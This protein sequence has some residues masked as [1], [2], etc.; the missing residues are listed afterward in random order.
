MALSCR[1]S[2]MGFALRWSCDLRSV[3]TQS[4]LTLFPAFVSITTVLTFLRSLQILHTLLPT[5][6]QTHSLFFINYYS[7]HVCIYLYKYSSEYELSQYNVTCM[8]V[9]RAHNLALN[10]HLMRSSHSWHS[11][12]VYS[13]CIVRSLVIFSLSTLAYLFLSY[14][15]I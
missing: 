10:N 12:A 2:K 15:F 3:V 5:F 11:S 13:L 1:L 6:L 14:L 7:M 9:L 4:S 8:Y